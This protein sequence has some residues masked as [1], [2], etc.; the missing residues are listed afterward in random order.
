[1]KFI[2]TF[3]GLLFLSN[4]TYSKESEILWSFDTNDMCY[5]QAAMADLDG[6]GFY[7]IVFGCY[8]NDRMVYVLNAED[9]S[10]FWKYDTEGT[11]GGCNDASPIIYDIDKD[12]A[13]EVIVASSCNN[14]TYCFEG[15][16]GKIKWQTSTNGSDSPPTIIDLDGD[17]NLE[18]LHG[19]F[20]GYVICINGN[21]GIVKWEILVDENSWIQTAPTIVDLD[22]DGQLDFVVATWHFYE[23]NKLYA[24]N[25]K[26]REILWS[27]DLNDV[28]YHGTTLVDINNDGKQELIIGDYSGKLY[29]LNALDGA[30][31]WS[32]Q[33]PVR[34]YSPVL[35][36]DLDGDGFCD[37]VFAS[38]DRVVAL[39]KDGTL[40]WEYILP[41]NDF[42]FRG[43]ALS[44]IDNDGLVDLVFGTYNGYLIA[45]K[46]TNGQPIWI[47]NL[48]EYYGDIYRIDH[49]PVIGDFNKDGKLDCFIVGGYSVYPDFSNN[50]GRAYAIVAGTGQGP[51]WTMFQHDIRRT[52]SICET[53][54]TSVDMLEQNDFLFSVY[55][56]PTLGELF[57]G[58]SS[59][60]SC[61]LKI[62]NIF[63]NTVYEND[64][65]STPVSIDL[66]KQPAGMYILKAYFDNITITRK[67]IKF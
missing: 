39:N 7:E 9:G 44:D 62:V 20:G 67:L 65:F 18:I 27:F 2:L 64:A 23:N 59:I 30:M 50:R 3:I 10:L 40:I 8:R 37:I 34:I 11:Y 1:M 35:S 38:N 61:H 24:Y 47:N 13:L 12:G 16:T 51:D 52:G 17:G 36:G 5:G 29:A 58:F 6:D 57:V 22:D 31:I 48:A 14:V 28:V 26:T 55:P 45:L 41:G 25:G 49:A 4:I 19:E 63:G 54:V 66:C 42:S 53:E 33:V 46:G 15:A 43:P 32:F 21:D 60:N 56:N